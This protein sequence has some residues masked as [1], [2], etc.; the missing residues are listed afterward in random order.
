MCK[1]IPVCSCTISSFSHC[2]RVWAIGA[3]GHG[4]DEVDGLNAIDKSKLKRYMKM[5]S[6]PEE[7]TRCKRLAPETMVNGERRDVAELAYEILSDPKRA[8]GVKSHAKYKKREESRSM[9]KRNFFVQK[10]HD[11][12]YYNLKKGSVSGYKTTE[13]RGHSNTLQFL[14]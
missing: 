6:E 11:V 12:M 9:E 10:K 1:A 4:K 13:A 3:L 8:Q 5:I 2:C 7:E 14:F